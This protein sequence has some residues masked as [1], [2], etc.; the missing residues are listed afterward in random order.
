MGL[1]ELLFLLL[2][3]LLDC[4]QLM[5]VLVPHRGQSLDQRSN[6]LLVLFNITV[7]RCIYSVCNLFVALALVLHHI[8]LLLYPLNS[9]HQLFNLS[10]LLIYYIPV[11]LHLLPILL[12]IFLPHSLHVLLQSLHAPLVVLPHLD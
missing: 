10:L 5:I 7:L 3:G 12:L 11:L 1:H 6:L 8:L 2:V 4:N 9:L